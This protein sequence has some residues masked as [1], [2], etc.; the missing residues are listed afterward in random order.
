M[1]PYFDKALTFLAGALSEEDGSRSTR[2]LVLVAS[3]FAAICFSAGLLIK[4]PE[5][6]VDL[7]KFTVQNC[8]IV[9]G[10]TKGIE[11]FKPGPP[12]PPVPA[13]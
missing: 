11:L 9:Y 1:K 8:I 3:I 7:I 2:R 13:V 5:M 12:P 6:C 4:H 10:A